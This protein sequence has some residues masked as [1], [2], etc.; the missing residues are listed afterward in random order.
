M[1]VVVLYVGL[2]RSQFSKLW[3]SYKFRNGLYTTHY[4]KMWLAFY[5]FQ[6]GRWDRYALFLYIRYS[7]LI[8]GWSYAPYKF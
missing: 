2:Y 4:V 6:K 3:F 5:V 1:V 7:C 8:T